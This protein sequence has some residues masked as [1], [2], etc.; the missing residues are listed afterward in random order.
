MQRK[1]IVSVEDDTDGSHS[2]MLFNVLKVIIIFYTTLRICN[3]F[4]VDSP[5]QFS[6]SAITGKANNITGAVSLVIPIWGDVPLASISGSLNTGITLSIGV[7]GIAAGS[8][9]LTYVN[10][11]VQAVISLSTAVKNFDNLTFQLF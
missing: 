7:W 3:F 1:D 6:L 4:G 11:G 9:T 10:S 8:I 5:F 2:I